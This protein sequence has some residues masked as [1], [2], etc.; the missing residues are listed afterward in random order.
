ML[1]LSSI[2]DIAAKIAALGHGTNQEKVSVKALPVDIERLVCDD[3]LRRQQM[4]IAK[5]GTTVANNPL[6]HKQ[7]LQHA[8]EEALDMAIYLKRAMHD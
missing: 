6:T 2:K 5:Y 8:Y 7:W 4:G 1:T 3:I